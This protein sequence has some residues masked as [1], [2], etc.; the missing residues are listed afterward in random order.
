MGGGCVGACTTK[1]SGST[2]NVGCL[3]L[4]VHVSIQAS[5]LYKHAHT[6]IYTHTLSHARTH[7]HP[8]NL[9][10][11]PTYKSHLQNKKSQMLAIVATPAY[12]IAV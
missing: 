9:N 10:H 3:K 6:N 11:S 5:Q 7:D 8:L 1:G 2:I 4:Y 12:D